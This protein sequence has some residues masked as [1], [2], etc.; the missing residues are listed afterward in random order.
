MGLLDKILAKLKLQ[1]HLEEDDDAFEDVRALD[2]P[3]KADQ[4]PETVN[5][6]IDPIFLKILD[7]KIKKSNEKLLIG[8][9]SVIDEIV[10]DSDPEDQSH[11]NDTV[12]QLRAEVKKN[13]DN[14]ESLKSLVDEK[15]K[16]HTATLDAF[17]DV[18]SERVNNDRVL[19]DCFK[20]NDCPF[21]PKIK[22]CK[23]WMHR[24]VKND[25][26]NYCSP[27]RLQKM[28]REKGL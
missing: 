20:Q 7:D 14:T 6:G 11:M 17:I 5:V 28:L 22:Q 12:E 4:K 24:P 3:P 8:V 15:I 16:E 2:L 23:I 21:D 19:A 27:C 1:R 9:A 18:I 10:K 13:Q 25:A 26:P